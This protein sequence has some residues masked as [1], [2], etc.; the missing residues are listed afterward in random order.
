MLG[1]AVP[2]IT[3][4]HTA[5]GG[6]LPTVIVLIVAVVAAVVAYGLARTREGATVHHLPHRERKAA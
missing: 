4:V 1:I 6:W 5:G 2:P 3:P